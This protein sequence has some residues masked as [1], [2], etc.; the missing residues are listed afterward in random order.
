MEFYLSETD[1]NMLM[2]EAVQGN[3]AY[4]DGYGVELFLVPVPERMIA[5]D[6]DRIRQ[7][8]DNLISNAI[9]FSDK[10][11]VVT[12][13]ALIEQQGI[14]IEVRDNGPGISE[15]F[16]PHIFKKFSQS[17]SSDTRKNSGAG[18]GLSIIEAHGGEIGFI[19]EEING[20]IF[21]I[22]LDAVTRMR[23]ARDAE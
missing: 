23:I 21:Y 6:K 20:A 17:D 15:S 5:V 1:L 14:R 8:L 10:G 7:V 16:R 18:P 12:I 22:V 4:A 11:D 3:R 2:T 19:S 9:I 13:K